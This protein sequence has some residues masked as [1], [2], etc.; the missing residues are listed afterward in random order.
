MRVK[1]AVLGDTI[2]ARNYCRTREERE[3]LELW[4]KVEAYNEVGWGTTASA[5]SVWI[6]QFLACAASASSDIFRRLSQWYFCP[7][8]L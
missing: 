6:A 4:A 7:T 2:T 8:A 3:E 5:A 1:I